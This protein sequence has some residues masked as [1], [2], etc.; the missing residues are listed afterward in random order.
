MKTQYR[1]GRDEEGYNVDGDPIPWSEE[2]DGAAAR[3]LRIGEEG[4]PWD[5]L[6]LLTGNILKYLGDDWEGIEEVIELAT[7]A[8]D[9]LTERIG[10][11]EDLVWQAMPAGPNVFMR[12]EQA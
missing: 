3:L 12:A 2:G 5:N 9:D 1:T 4:F 8:M 7:A 11:I 6:N 10:A